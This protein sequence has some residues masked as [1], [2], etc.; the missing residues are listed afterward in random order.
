MDGVWAYCAG[1]R[2]SDHEWRTI[3]PTTR[4]HLETA[5]QRS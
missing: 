5:P 2:D 3:E 4:R 1:H